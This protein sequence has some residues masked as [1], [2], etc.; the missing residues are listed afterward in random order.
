MWARHGCGAEGGAHQPL[1][2]PWSPSAPRR[3]GGTSGGGGG[4]GRL[5]CRR[6]ARSAAG[7]EVPGA[8]DSKGEKAGSACS[9]NQRRLQAAGASL[10]APPEPPPPE[11]ITEWGGS[12][13]RVCTAFVGPTRRRALAGLPGPARCR[14]SRLLLPLSLRTLGGD[15]RP[16]RAGPVSFPAASPAGRLCCSWPRGLRDPLVLLIQPGSGP[17]ALPASSLH[18]M[19]C[20]GF[21]APGVVWGRTTERGARS[22]R[23]AVRQAFGVARRGPPVG[24]WHAPPFLRSSP[25]RCCLYSA[26]CASVRF[27]TPPGVSVTCQMGRSFL[28]NSAMRFTCVFLCRVLDTPG[29]IFP[30][31]TLVLP[32]GGG[33]TWRP[34]VR[35]CVWAS[36]P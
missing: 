18:A 6:G 32:L 8:P 27:P 23:T 5:W 2:G 25:T 17:E 19:T 1:L 15:R 12:P 3:P 13:E 31:R 9:Q 4:W 10:P 16:C 11:A 34:P 35:G 29:Q 21:W 24:L 33:D 14:P 36:G 7:L 22:R 20:G 28:G 30:H 26:H